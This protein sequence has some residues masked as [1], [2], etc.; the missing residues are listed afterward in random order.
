MGEERR[1]ERDGG[2]GAL[3][4]RIVGSEGFYVHDLGASPSPRDAEGA[5]IASTSDTRKNA[6]R[7]SVSPRATQ[8]LSGKAVD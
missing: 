1:T 5:V 4:A 8:L 6:E 7:P 3:A 2:C